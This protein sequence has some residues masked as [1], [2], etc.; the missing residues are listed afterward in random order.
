MEITTVQFCA[1][2]MQH[3]LCLLGYKDSS[4]EASYN[5]VKDCADVQARPNNDDTPLREIVQGGS[6]VRNA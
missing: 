4:E 1:I 6:Q 5:E 2:Y 3:Q